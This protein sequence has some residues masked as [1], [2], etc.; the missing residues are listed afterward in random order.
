MTVSNVLPTLLCPRPCAL[1]L[2]DSSSTWTLLP[3]CLGVT[4]DFSFRPLLCSLGT[5]LRKWRGTSPGPPCASHIPSPGRAQWPSWPVLLILPCSSV[6]HLSYSSSQASFKMC[7]TSSQ[8][9][10]ECWRAPMA[11]K[12]PRCPGNFASC[13]SSTSPRSLPHT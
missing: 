5:P 12:G 3:T 4:L 13:C 11:C 6:G 7:R 9:C 1:E 2:M 8:V 10:S